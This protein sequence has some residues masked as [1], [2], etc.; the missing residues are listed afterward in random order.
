MYWAST[1][2]ISTQIPGLNNGRPRLRI[3]SGTKRVTLADWFVFRGESPDC[4]LFG[5]AS[6]LGW[7][8][9]LLPHH[10]HGS[11]TERWSRNTLRVVT[12]RVFYVIR[13][14]LT[15]PFIFNNSVETAAPFYVVSH[16]WYSEPRKTISDKVS[17]SCWDRICDPWHQVPGT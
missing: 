2:I 17:T 13:G 4:R 15:S 9:N 6:M 1:E 7:L 11:S 10:S 14:S 12:A 3:Y 5:T 8:R 16:P